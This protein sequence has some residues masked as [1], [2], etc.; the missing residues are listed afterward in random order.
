MTD[1]PEISF[2]KMDYK[3]QYRITLILLWLNYSAL[4]IRFF[5]FLQFPCILDCISRSSLAVSRQTYFSTVFFIL[6]H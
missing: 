6:I 2:L 1:F 4:V 3:V 5:E